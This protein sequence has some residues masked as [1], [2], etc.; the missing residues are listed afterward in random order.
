MYEERLV[1][2]RPD[3]SV[4]LLEAH[5]GRGYEVGGQL[6]LAPTAPMLWYVFTDGWASVARFHLADGSFAGFYTNLSTPVEKK[7]NTWSSTDLFLDLW[8]PANGEPQWLDEDELRDAKTRKLLN[9]WTVSRVQR[10]RE[11]IEALLKA[12]AWPPA[13]CH[14]IDLA[15]IRTSLHESDDT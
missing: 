12:G 2:D 5:R 1:V 4:L 3:V 6:V 10:E 14:E 9:D 8:I 11:R 7:G 15:L 13:V